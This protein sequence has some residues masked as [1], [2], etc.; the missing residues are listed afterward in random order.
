MAYSPMRELERAVV[1]KPMVVLRVGWWLA[2]AIVVAVTG[3]LAYPIRHASGWFVV[4]HVRNALLGMAIATVCC[5][6]LPQSAAWI[7]LVLFTATCWVAGTIDA[8]GAPRWWAI[9]F[10]L[11]DSPIAGAVSAGL[12]F[13]SLLAYARFERATSR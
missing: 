10:Y 4:S 5:V 6:V 12:A 3:A 2:T 13:A 1:G 11:A 7:P 8:T 9:P